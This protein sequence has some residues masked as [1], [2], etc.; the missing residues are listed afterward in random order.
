[1]EKSMR[2][3]VSHLAIWALAVSVHLTHDN[4][5]QA[6]LMPVGS[7]V[8]PSGSDFVY[9]YNLA[10]TT[11]ATLQSGDYFTIYNFPGLVANSNTQPTGFAFSSAP[12][13][14]GTSL[15]NVTWTFTASSA[16]IGPATLGNFTVQ[17]QFGTATT[18]SFASLAQTLVGDRAVSSVTQAS[19][20]IPSGSASCGSGTTVTTT[21]DPSGGA[22]VPEPSSLAL[23]IG[24]PLLAFLWVR[25][26]QA[27]AAIAKMST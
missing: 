9:S 14:T 23:G 24:L 11:N 26:Q 3:V 8:T 22:S 12:S 21:G 15:S 13:S 2:L 6:G 10:L 4:A 20:T 1:M 7:T 18:G 19:I 16:P 5:C 17:S 27:S 25:R